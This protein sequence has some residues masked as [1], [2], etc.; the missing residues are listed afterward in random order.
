MANKPVKVNLKRLVSRKEVLDLVNALSIFSGSTAIL[1]DGGKVIYGD[2]GLLFSNRHPVELEDKIIGWVN[3]DERASLIAQLLSYMVTVEAEKKS[4]GR[5]T[6]E[7][8]KEIT[9]LY[10]ITEMLATN[11]DPKEVAQLIVIEG[12]KLVK[13]DNISVM[14]V[15]EE[16]GCLEVICALKSVSHPRTSM[17]AGEGIAGRVLLSGV[18]ELVSDVRFDTRYI[19]G[20][21]DVLS[22]MCAPLKIKDKVIGVVNVSSLQ[23]DFY[24]SGDLKLLSALALQLAAAIENARLFSNLEKALA[25]EKKA[26]QEQEELNIAYSRFVPHEFLNHLKRESI[27]DVQLGDQ[28]LLE[29]TVLFSDIRSFTSLSEKMTPEENFRFINS[30]LK[31]ME[32]IVNKYNGFIDKFIGDAIMALFNSGADDALDSAISMLQTLSQ[33]NR[34]RKRH[35]QEQLRIG[36][37]LNTGPVILGIVGGYNRMDGTVI[38]D[39]VNL[40]SRIE[41][42]N[43][44]YGSNLLIS[45]RT[46]KRLK[47]PSKYHIR[48]IGQVKVKGKTEFVKVYE[49]FDAD[50]PEVKSAKLLTKDNFEK[51]CAMFYHRDL[52]T[53][54][55]KDLQEAMR[56]FGECLAQNP[57]DNIAGKYTEQCRELLN[58]GE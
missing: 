33:Y 57:G 10:S 24:T 34:V 37:G 50:L 54:N 41:G 27:T 35:G 19:A 15:N 38:S 21:N 39:A 5:E 8:Y 58:K 3:G 18:A 40:A 45:G 42:L 51:A 52:R 32:P 29:M 30:Y 46:Y 47:D 55:K 2:A 11:L 23:P 28:S 9:M 26:R 4:L 56:L 43:K 13:A 1:D 20:S 12:K 6:L 14:L 48:F 25:Q 44:I 53:K 36:I 31:D 17:K 49:V 7:K 22:L 16:S